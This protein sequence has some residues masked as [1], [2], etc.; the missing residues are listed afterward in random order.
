MATSGA[1]KHW[2]AANG[3][4]IGTVEAGA[5]TAPDNTAPG[6]TYTTAEQDIIANLQARVAWLEAQVQE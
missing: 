3:L 1:P 5:V 6:G 4:P 2:I